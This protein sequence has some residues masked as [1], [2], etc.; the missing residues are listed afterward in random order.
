MS[1]NG[2]PS[3]LEQALDEMTSAIDEA[4]RLEKMKKVQQYVLLVPV[5]TRYFILQ[6]LKQKRPFNFINE[7]K[8]K[9]RE[10]STDAFLLRPCKA[11]VYSWLPMTSNDVGQME[12]LTHDFV[13][14]QRTAKA[15]TLYG[16]M[17]YKFMRHSLGE[18]SMF[19]MST[20]IVKIGESLSQAFCLRDLGDRYGAP[21]IATVGFSVSMNMLSHSITFEINRPDEPLLITTVT[22]SGKVIKKLMDAND[23]ENTIHR[24]KKDI[25]VR[26]L[27]VKCP[28]FDEDDITSYAYAA[29]TDAERLIDVMIKDPVVGMMSV[30]VV[31]NSML[32]NFLNSTL[33]VC[34]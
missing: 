16:R 4:D 11:T 33:C 20:V 34:I 27:V 22:I 5:D 17:A 25:N 7:P 12:R 30:V 8:R 29:V 24:Y 23:H 9:D 18:L 2:I 14:V 31:K 10:V 1:E 28:F 26:I 3:D 32:H 19:E 21:S 13:D 6:Q 15:D